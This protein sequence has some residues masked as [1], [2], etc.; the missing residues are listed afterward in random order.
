LRNHVVTIAPITEHALHAANLAFDAIET[1][2]HLGAGI[3]AQ[4]K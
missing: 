4:L 1:R 3:I 2:H